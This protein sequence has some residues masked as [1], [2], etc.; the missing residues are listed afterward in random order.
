MPL[1]DVRSPLRTI[2][3]V[4]A[5]R[6]TPNAKNNPLRREN[7][8]KWFGGTLC[9]HW[10]K[11]WGRVH[12]DTMSQWRAI[13]NCPKRQALPLFL[14]GNYAS[15]L[16]EAE[17]Q[18]VFRLLKYTAF[19]L[20]V[21][22]G[23]QTKALYLTIAISLPHLAKRDPCDRRVTKSWSS[24]LVVVFMSRPWVSAV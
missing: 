22:G 5:I 21:Y 1:K 12:S 15:N 16:L 8:V 14:G 6:S 4:K 13:P 7:N 19:V 24:I 23:P 17:R 11:L 10:L 3:Q 2:K 18:V 20:G 9:G